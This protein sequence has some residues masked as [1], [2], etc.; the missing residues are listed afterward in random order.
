MPEVAV[1][2][3]HGLLQLKLSSK[4]MSGAGSPKHHLRTTLPPSTTIQVNRVKGSTT[5]LRA[6][7]RT[8][9]IFNWRADGLKEKKE[10]Y[11]QKRA[12]QRQQ[13]EEQWG[14]NLEFLQT[15]DV[16]ECMLKI[17]SLILGK[18][19]ADENHLKSLVEVPGK[20]VVNFDERVK[21]VAEALTMLKY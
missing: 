13:L 20:V 14:E 11:L 18:L 5:T 15:L 10:L 9:R 21:E 12:K 3:Y 17:K 19:A 8:R 7:P 16:K 6:K 1:S 4:V 2:K